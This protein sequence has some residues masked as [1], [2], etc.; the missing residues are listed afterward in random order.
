MVAEVRLQRSVAGHPNV[1]CVYDAFENE[2]DFYVV[3]ELLRGGEVMKHITELGHISERVAAGYFVQMV[4]GVMWCHSKGVIHRDIKPENFLLADADDNTTVKVADFGLSCRGVGPD[5]RV[6]FGAAC[7]TPHFIAPEMYQQPRIP[8]TKAVDAWSLGVCLYLMLSGTLPFGADFYRVEDI[9]YTVLHDELRFEEASWGTMSSLPRELIAGLLERDVS[10]RYTLEQVAAHPWL[11]GHAS[12]A[13]LDRATIT[14][15]TTYQANNC[16]KR[17]ALELASEQL[18][19]VD[20]AALRNTF[21]AIDANGDGRVTAR[22]MAAAV[23]GLGFANDELRTLLGQIGNGALSWPEFLHATAERILQ[24][25]QAAIWAVFRQLDFSGDDQIS[26]DE[27]RKAGGALGQEEF[28]QLE[29]FIAEAD[30]VSERTSQCGLW[31]VPGVLV[32]LH[33]PI[34]PTG[35]RQ[36]CVLC[37]VYCSTFTKRPSVSTGEA[38]LATC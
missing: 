19:A 22:E 14:A 31:E 16:F 15:L 17:Q 11:N 7:G 30:L 5:I 38:G 37:R 6:D 12:H 27:L 29:R 32:F 8:Y 9:S 4:R 36:S 28:A 23:A 26:A 34:H 21:F 25:H 13:A 3:M 18:T 10:K 2:A 20:V 35:R 33:L 24:H 1:T